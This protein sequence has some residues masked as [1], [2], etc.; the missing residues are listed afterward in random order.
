VNWKGLIVE[1][2]RII[3]DHGHYR[4]NKILNTICQNWFDCWVDYKTQQSLSHVD[5]QLQNLV[6]EPTIENPI[7]S[8]E[9]DGETLLGG[10]MRLKSHWVKD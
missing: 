3:W 6:K 1:I 9:K 2:I 4:N 5:L 10:E 8:E 7:F